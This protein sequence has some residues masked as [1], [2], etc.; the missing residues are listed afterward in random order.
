MER[1]EAD[2]SYAFRGLSA[3][4]ASFARAAAV[5]SEIYKGI[6][7]SVRRNKYNNFQR[8]AYTRWYEK[9]VLANR[10]LR[11]LRKTQKRP[12]IPA[13]QSLVVPNKEVTTNGKRPSLLTLFLAAMVLL[14]GALTTPLLAVQSNN[15]SYPDN[16]EYAN[17][18]NADTEIIKQLRSQYLEAVEDEQVIDQSLS[19]LG[20]IEKPT[21]AMEAYG[22]A[23]TVLRAKHAFWPIKKMKHLRDGLPRLDTLLVNNP[24]N[25]E[26]GYL[27]LMSCYYLPR[28]LGRGDTVKEDIKALAFLLP[29]AE[30]AYPADMYRHMVRFVATSKELD[31]QEKESLDLILEK[32]QDAPGA[33]REPR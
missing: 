7:R 10:A 31:Q 14:S 2:Y 30:A 18:A 9:I 15:A 6:H 21:P 19:M 20:T 25:I 12:F 11:R 32:A 5:A 17:M 23:L 13:K 16:F 8:R 4:P 1:A 24:V 33:A 27:R 26:I 3:I 28:F 29:S 22:A